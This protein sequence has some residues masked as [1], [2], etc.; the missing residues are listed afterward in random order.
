MR[1]LKLDGPTGRP[2][3]ASV[4]ILVPALNV[5]TSIGGRS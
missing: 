1:V 3:L 5:T 2:A 4:V